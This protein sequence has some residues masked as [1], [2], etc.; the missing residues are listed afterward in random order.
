MSFLS[1]VEGRSVTPSFSLDAKHDS[2]F[3]VV[4]KNHYRYIMIIVYTSVPHRSRQAAGP[5]ESQ[6]DQQRSVTIA[7][8]SKRS[9]KQKTTGWCQFQIA[10]CVL[11]GWVRKTNRH[12][13]RALD[14]VR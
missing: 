5:G 7:G 2:K 12:L 10:L 14:T 3:E 11:H 13:R 1:P 8:Y 4:T 6:V 9:G